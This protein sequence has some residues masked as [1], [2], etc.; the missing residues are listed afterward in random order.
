[1]LAQAGVAVRPRAASASYCA[2]SWSGGS[3][4]LPVL[5]VGSRCRRPCARGPCA[6][7]PVEG[8]VGA[9]HG[10]LQA[11]M[12]AAL[13]GC[14]VRAEADLA[15]MQASTVPFAPRAA[16]THFPLQP[17]RKLDLALASFRVLASDVHLRD[18]CRL[19]P[20]A[21]GTWPSWPWPWRVSFA[22]RSLLPSDR[23]DPT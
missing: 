6:C 18:S 13:S 16:P 10:S 15:C 8:A 12:S 9:H 4:D 20:A 19:L 3:G 1:M 21:A 2:S 11:S 14:W 22:C 7:V 5:K 23:P 17:C